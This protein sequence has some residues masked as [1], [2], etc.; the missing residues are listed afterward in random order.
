MKRLVLFASV[1]LFLNAESIGQVEH[2]NLDKASKALQGYD[3][4]S[5]FKE[6]KAVRGKKE[7]TLKHNGA[8]YWF[9]NEQNRE[10]FREDP[11]KFSIEYGGWCAYA[12][13]VNGEKVKV[14]PE[15]FKVIDGKLYLFYNFYFTNTLTKWNEDEASLKKRADVNWKD[16]NKH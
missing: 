2:L 15:T 16:L 12:M 6:N 14:D 10:L 11:S 7:F 9:E 13:G 8:I 5:Y 4:V 1:C 3:A